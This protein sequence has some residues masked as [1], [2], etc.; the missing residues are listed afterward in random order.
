MPNYEGPCAMI[1][2]T[3]DGDKPARPVNANAVKKY[4]VKNTKK[5]SSI[6]R[7]TEKAT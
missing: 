3:M 7:K 5:K 4:F 6:G 1:L 2:T